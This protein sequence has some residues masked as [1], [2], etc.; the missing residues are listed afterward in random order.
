[1]QD[2]SCFVIINAAPTSL[3]RYHISQFPSTVSGIVFLADTLTSRAGCSSH[4]I[5][6]RCCLQ[7]FELK[8]LETRASLLKYE[9]SS[10]APLSC[11]PTDC[12]FYF[13]LV[14]KIS[15]DINPTF[16]FTFHVSLPCASRVLGQ[17]LQCRCWLPNK[18]STWILQAKP[19][20]IAL[21]PCLRTGKSS[22]GGDSL[23]PEHC[24]KQC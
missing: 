11:G 23:L 19:R 20:E 4:W 14:E 3:H 15:S 5:L 8:C 17:R 10:E 7:A 18:T 6:F 9:C 22:S 2:R 12:C 24:V 16:A 21:G 1:M 13:P